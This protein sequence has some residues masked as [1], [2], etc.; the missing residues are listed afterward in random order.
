[1]RKYNVT[2]CGFGAIGHSIAV[3]IGKSSDFNINILTKNKKEK[4]EKIQ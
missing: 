1:M 2:I 3:Q 4:I